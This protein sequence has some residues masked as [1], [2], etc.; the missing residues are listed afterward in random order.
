MSKI[1]VN[2][3]TARSGTTITVPTGDT[4]AVTSNA[5]VGGTLGITSN[6][7]V[8]G[9]LAVTGVHTI[10]TNAIFTS[11]GGATS[12]LLRRSVAKL[13]V[14]YADN[15]SI[16]DQ[17]NISSITDGGTGVHTPF[18]TSN[19]A[20]T[21]YTLVAGCGGYHEHCCLAGRSTGSFPSY[22]RNN[23]SN[24]GNY[25]INAMIAG[26]GDLA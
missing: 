16:N 3:I 22:G 23:E 26:F 14:N 25:D 10:G 1:E 8:G 7:T 21:V 15:A 2:E 18:L 5:T 9:T 24:S 12:L 11:D 20:N 19:M 13:F 6:A 4:L 17:I